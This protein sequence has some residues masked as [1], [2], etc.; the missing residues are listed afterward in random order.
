MST[1]VLFEPPAVVAL[2]PTYAVLSW[3]Q[4]RTPAKT[5]F[6]EHT[7]WAYRVEYNCACRMRHQPFALSTSETFALVA[8]PHAGETYYV[9]VVARAT[10]AGA[11]AGLVSSKVSFVAQSTMALP[12]C[13]TDASPSPYVYD[14]L[15]LCSAEVGDTDNMSALR[16]L[17]RR[18]TEHGCLLDRNTTLCVTDGDVECRVHR[19][20]YDSAAPPGNRRN[21]FFMA[22]TGRRTRSGQRM[23]SKDVE[24]RLQQHDAALVFCGVGDRGRHAAKAAHALLSSFTTSRP[25]LSRCVFCVTFGTPRLF[26][27]DEGQLLAHTLPHSF[28]FLHVTQLPLGGGASLLGEEAAVTQHQ[29]GY[30]DGFYANTLLGVRCAV[31]RGQ[32]S[33]AEMLQFEPSSPGVPLTWAE[34]A[35]VYDVADALQRLSRLLFPSTPSWLTPSISA[36]RCRAVGPLLRV[37]VEG[38]ALHYCPRV[39]VLPLRHTPAFPSVAECGPL[40]LSCVGSL[41]P[42]LEAL[43]D[44]T[45]SATGLPC[46][47]DIPLRVLVQTSFGTAAH[48]SAATFSLPMD[49]V[50]LYRAAASAATSG[51]SPW[52]TAA[53]AALL[54]GALQTQPLYALC[55][56]TSDAAGGGGGAVTVTS[57]PSSNAPLNPVAEVLCSMA[58]AAEAVAAETARAAAAGGTSSLFDFVTARLSA[59]VSGAAAGASARLAV[60]QR[61]AAFLRNALREWVASASVSIDMWRLRS[62]SWRHRVLYALP[63]LGDQLYKATLVEMLSRFESCVEG[64]E[65]VPLLWLEARLYAHVRLHVAQ[66]ESSRVN[67]D[68][69]FCRTVT[70]A[71]AYSALVDV[72]GPVPTAGEKANAVAAAAASASVAD[73]LPY[74]EEVML[75]WCACQCFELRRE[76]SSTLLCCTVGCAGCGG[77]TLS[78]ALASLLLSETSLTYAHTTRRRRTS[79]CRLAASRLP[80]LHMAMQTGVPIAVFLAGEVADVVRPQYAAMAMHIQEDLSSP[81]QHWFRVITKADEHLQHIKTSDF[82]LSAHD[83]VAALLA[84]AAEEALGSNVTDE[85]RVAVSLAPSP[86]LLAQVLQCSAERANAF[87]AAL[88]AVSRAFLLRCLLLSVGQEE[89]KAKE[90]M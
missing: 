18:T 85:H 86:V 21:V 67:M 44:S 50:E 11:M 48:T 32:R 13:T 47:S 40:R 3:Q 62:S 78:A 2:F 45:E 28:H 34:T 87:A 77:S 72:F 63:A 24:A 6:A 27:K 23:R 5:A 79:T 76:L 56:G 65:G 54:E 22:A 35:E 90:V 75:L 88:R 46:E 36:V 82:D 29:T 55:H 16:D 49:L 58:S 4:P 39:T 51:A 69:L 66:G 59:A 8:T 37:T 42:W 60:P 61:E 30:A 31:V 73:S 43:A 83:A 71:E 81:V 57:G 26:L 33:R 68:E 20:T 7:S 9:R 12:W 15:F 14:A 10:L 17:R 89:E 25:A 19:A 38:T 52:A 53:P 70:I 1:A 80:A 84:E 41:L 64:G 74:L